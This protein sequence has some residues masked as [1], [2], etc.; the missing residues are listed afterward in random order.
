MTQGNFTEHYNFTLE[1]GTETFT[2]QIPRNN[3]S[4]IDAI[5]GTY[6]YLDGMLILN[7]ITTLYNG[8]VLPRSTVPCVR[9]SG[10]GGGEVVEQ[11]FEIRTAVYDMIVIY[12]GQWRDGKPNGA[13]VAIVMK[14]IPG[15]FAFGDKLAGM[16][17]NGLLEGPGVY[18]SYD[19]IYQLRGTFIN[20]LKEGPVQQYQN[21]V[22]IRDMEFVNGSPVN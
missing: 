14:D 3:T 22:Y 16:W 15:R 2:V 18:V 5:N 8:S 12:I 21:G 1:L 6:E 20:G 19:G 4:G 9:V 11:D 17:V 13:G 10:S 7:I